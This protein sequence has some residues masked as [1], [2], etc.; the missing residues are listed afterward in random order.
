[1]AN[2]ESQIPIVVKIGD[3]VKFTVKDIN[4]TTQYLGK[5]V[6]I[7]DYQSAKAYSDIDVIHQ[8]MLQNDATLDNPELMR[9]LVI[10]CYDGVRRPFAFQPDGKNS[11][12]NNNTLEIVELGGEYK[13][14]LYNSSETDATLAIRILRE[15]GF[16]CQ[17]LK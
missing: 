5:V 7:V 17:L 1:M 10:E 9:Y 3:Q 6:A 2:L 15:H 16:T 4:D 12:F 11:W 14:K 8:A 13:I